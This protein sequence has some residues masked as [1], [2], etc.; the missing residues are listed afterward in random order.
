MVI[1]MINFRLEASPL[2]CDFLTY[3]QVVK[4]HSPKTVNEYYLDLRTFFR[5]MKLQKGLAECDINEISIKDVNIDFIKTITLSDVYSF[6]DYLSHEKSKFHNSKD[7][8]IGISSTTIARKLAA[9]RSF[10]KY[11]VSK[12]HLLDENPIADLDTPKRK[13][14]LPKYLN[15]DESVTLLTNIDNKN[16]F[17]KARDYCIITLF[18]NCGLRVSELVG[19]NTTDLR[20]EA[21]KVTGKGAKERVVYL[22]DACISAINDYIKFRTNIQCN[23]KY[24]FFVSQKHNRISKGAVELLV[25]K[26]LKLSG[27]DSKKYSTHKL[28]HT[29]ATLMLQNGV[30]VRTLQEVLGHENLNTTQIYTHVDNESLRIAARSNPLADIKKE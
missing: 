24:A 3:H 17:L 26:Y 8:Q 6:M 1:V 30:D 2:I 4:N 22:N 29:A 16:E 5:F 14:T 20:D 25:K 21:L 7:I 23:D 13:K 15:L 28:R 9:I 12:V 11:L 18:L 10:Y 19:I 27:L